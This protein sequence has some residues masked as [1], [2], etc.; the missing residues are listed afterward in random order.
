MRQ[1][2]GNIE[3]ITDNKPRLIIDGYQL[4]EK[5]RKDFD[6][7]PDEDFPNASFVRYKGE[8]YDLGDFMILN[9]RTVGVE[10]S[11]GSLG[12]HGYASDSYFSGVVI[13]YVD[14]DSDRVVMGWY[15]VK[16]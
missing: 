10:P 15:Y 12:W 3:V 14:G 2:I 9:P 13:R 8:L 11:L 7:I 1:K 6:Y 5:E 16:G 4:S